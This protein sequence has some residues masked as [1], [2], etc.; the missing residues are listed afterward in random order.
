MIHD[1]LIFLIC[2]DLAASFLFSFVYIGCKRSHFTVRR[3]KEGLFVVVVV[4]LCVVWERGQWTLGIVFGC[5]HCFTFSCTFYK[6][7]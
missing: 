2:L 4:L 5:L 3:G 6:V 1:T 7:F